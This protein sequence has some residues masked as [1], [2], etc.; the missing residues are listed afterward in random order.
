MALHDFFMKL[1]VATAGQNPNDGLH[2][3]LA[4]VGLQP[5]SQSGAQAEYGGQFEGR[6]AML[7]VDGSAVTAAGNA[8]YGRAIGTEVAAGLGLISGGFADWRNQ[9]NELHSRRGMREARMS[10][11]FGLD[12]G[13]PPAAQVLVSRDASMGHPVAQD[14]FVQ[15]SQEAWPHVTQAFVVQRLQ[16]GS[17]DQIRTQPNSTW[18]EAIFMP[19]MADYQRV[20]AD[21]AA[22]GRM[23]GGTLGAM[24]GLVQILC[25][26]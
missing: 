8:A 13:R 19:R 22:F 4:G 10:F 15:T 12:G 3:A 9:M 24:S 26:R 18:I 5:R 21:P 14:V 20:A 17:F 1:N 6:P 25:P 16:Q 2:R 23:V 11:H 7:R